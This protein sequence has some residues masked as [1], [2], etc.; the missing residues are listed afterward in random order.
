MTLQQLKY[1]VEV[2]DKGSM[3]EASKSLFISQ[4]SLSSAVMELEKELQITIF[5]RSSRGVAV[6]EKG[7]EFLGYARQVL[8]QTDLLKAKF[9][10]GGGEKQRFCV[11]SQHYLFVANAFVEL[12]KEY[13]QD[14]YD[15]A[16]YE[17]TTHEVIENVK[18]MFSEMGFIYL[19]NEN[20]TV[21][22]RILTENNLVFSSLFS[23]KPHV[24]LYRRHPLAQKTLIT[25]KELEDYPRISFNQGQYNSLYYSE[26][27][28]S[29][30]PVKKS[31]RVS[32]RAAVVNFLLGLNGYMFSS[33]VF[34]KDLH[35]D[36]VIAIP[37]DVEERIE[38]G[39]VMHKD[40][41][42]SELGKRFHEILEYTLKD[43]R[44]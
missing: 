18:T 28:L 24:F 4:P 9:V 7:A 10:D 6:T 12:V 35:G 33:G 14:S 16:L 21:M 30:K 41:V 5:T 17:T 13:G 1:V 37:L 19:S 25:L 22:R 31:I 20:E 8:A 34:P 27:I 40:A 43:V 26:E 36:D 23:A 32:D 44:T 38:I 11:S 15:F 3:N 39:T 42:M 29:A 2:A